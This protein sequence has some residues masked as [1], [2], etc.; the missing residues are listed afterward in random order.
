MT[1]ISS[2]RQLSDE[3]FARYWEDGLLVIQNV[4]D[5]PTIDLAKQAIVDLIPRDFIFGENFHSHSGRLKPLNEDGSDGFFTPELLPLL[6]NEMLYEV[7]ADLFETDYLRVLD[8][9]VGV[10]LKDAGPAGL[11]QRLH[12]DMHV[13]KPE[14]R[15]A[16]HLR[17]NVGMGGCYYLSDV[18]EN[19]AG[20][21][22]IPGG[23][24]MAEEIMLHEEDGLKRY[25][26][27]RNIN[28]MADSVEVTAH[29]GDFVLMHHMMPHGAS[30]NRN[31]TP[32]VAQF[33]RFHRLSEQDARQTPGPDRAFSA[34][35][36]EA[37][38][39]LG[40]KLFR[41]YPWVA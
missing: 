24:R 11:T 40:R 38:T 5:E 31:A 29:A 21:H 4:L 16:E 7:M 33:T 18:Q 30:R 25:E 19:G 41:F 14:E 1:T 2:R 12:L 20:I 28:D 32:R 23:H 36:V 39:P 15:S 9:S 26:N 22:V 17:F 27:W 6:I 34:A 37:L 35:A 13:P 3:Q 8:G 10:S